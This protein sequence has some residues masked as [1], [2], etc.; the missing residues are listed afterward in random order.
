MSKLTLGRIVHYTLSEADAKS[1]NATPTPDNK[2]DFSAGLVFAAVVVRLSYGVMPT[3]QVLHDIS[4]GS[5]FVRDAKEDE[6]DEQQTPG[7]WHWPPVSNSAPAQTNPRDQ[8]SAAAQI[9]GQ[10]KA[11]LKR[12]ESYQREAESDGAAQEGEIHARTAGVLRELDRLAAAFIA[13]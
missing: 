11:M 13:Q 5:L 6:T 4:A 9:H 7:T 10:I 8:K 1:L 12:A 2:E 3:L